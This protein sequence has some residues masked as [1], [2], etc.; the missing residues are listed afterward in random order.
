MKKDEFLTEMEITWNP[1]LSTGAIISRHG[2]EAVGPIPPD[3]MLKYQRESDEMK[4]KYE[5]ERIK[6]DKLYAEML[7]PV[8]WWK[9]VFKKGKI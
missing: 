1:P 9:K 2:V 6:Y 8:P 3:L 4:I 7:Y 5:E